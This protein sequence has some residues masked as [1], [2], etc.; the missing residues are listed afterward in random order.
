[1]R[2]ASDT[3]LPSSEKMLH[4]RRGLGHGADL[5]QFAAPE[6]DGDRADRVD[7]T[8]PSPASEVP[9]LLDDTCCVRHRVG[10]GHRVHGC[11]A[12]YRSSGRNPTQP[13]RRPR[14]PARAGG[15]AGRPSREGQPGRRHRSLS[16]SELR[17]SPPTAAITTVPIRRSRGSSPSRRPP[18]IRYAG[19]AHAA[20]PSAESLP[21]SSR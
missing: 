15:C 11:K 20:P 3:H 5:G 13:S 21:P 2:T 19:V 10:V 6:S 17:A 18:V 7:V 9:H 16:A 4:P 12:A 8:E 14:V 1:M